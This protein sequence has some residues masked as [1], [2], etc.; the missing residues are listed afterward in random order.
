MADRPKSVLDA[1]FKYAPAADTAKPGYLA[2]KWDRLYPNWR[3]KQP[4]L[5][6]AKPAVITPPV[7]EPP[8]LKLLQFVRRK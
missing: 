4:V 6:V 8:V 1:S 5:P 3:V 2:E 7:E